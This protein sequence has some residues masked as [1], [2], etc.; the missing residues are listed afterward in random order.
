MRI[1]LDLGATISF[2]VLAVLGWRKLRTS[3]NLWFGMLLVY[4]LL[5]PALVRLDALQSNQR[6]VL[7]M[8]PAFIILA[9]LGVKYPRLHQALLLT[10]PTLLATLGVLFIL[11]RWIV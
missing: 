2:M 4:S 10:F 1:I 5:S 3:Y 6:F 9:S 8:F 11:N 7:E